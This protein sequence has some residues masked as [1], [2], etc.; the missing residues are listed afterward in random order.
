MTAFARVHRVVPLLAGLMGA[1]GVGLAAAATHTGG[2][3]FLG[4][5]SAMCLAHAP[6]MLAL[7][8]GQRYL[9]TATLAA[10]VLALG[11]IVF[12]GDL[13]LR[14]FYGHGLF[15][16]AAPSGGMI[17]IAGWLLTAAGVLFKMPPADR[18]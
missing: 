14:Q 9:K 17:M 15:A 8:A 2:Q 12:A 1:A 6:A 13:S 7:Y 5:A 16:M 10:L 3:S 4:P 11:T 18:I